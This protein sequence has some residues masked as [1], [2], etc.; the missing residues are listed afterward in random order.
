MSEDGL[1]VMFEKI[2]NIK[3]F[4]HVFTPTVTEFR[5]GFPCIELSEMIERPLKANNWGGGFRPTI[6]LF[7]WCVRL[8]R[9]GSETRDQF[10]PARRRITA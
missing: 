1:D 3:D 6:M 4:P 7:E 2:G 10:T 9:R 5:S 8:L